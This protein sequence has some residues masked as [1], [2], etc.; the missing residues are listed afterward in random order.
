MTYYQDFLEF[1][2][3][4]GLIPNDELYQAYL[5]AELTT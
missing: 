4:V 1:C 2:Q 5:E 3:L